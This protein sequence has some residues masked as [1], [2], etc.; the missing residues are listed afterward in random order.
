VAGALRDAGEPTPVGFLDDG[1]ATRQV[2]G[3]PVLGGTEEVV[4]V[5][6]RAGVTEVVVAIPSLPAT[7][8]ALLIDRA[9]AAGLGVR[10]LPAGTNDVTGL[11][12][13][14]L[15]RLLGRPEITV[16]G[17][18]ARRSITGRRV[19]VTGA[20]GVIGAH[21]CRLLE[22]LEPAELYRLDLDESRL[23]SLEHVDDRGRSVIADVRDQRR[24]SH[25]ITQLRPEVVF[26]SAGHTGDPAELE[27]HPSAAIETDVRGTRN[28]VSAAVRGG[29]ER[30]VL[31]STDQAADPSSVLGATR[32][33][34]E[35]TVQSAAGGP[36]IF[37]TVRIGNVLG[38]GASLLSVLTTQVAAGR[39]VPVTHPDVSRYF[40]TSQEA[41]GLILEAAAMSEEAETFVLDT[42]APT[43]VVELVHRYAAQLRLP[44]VTIRF[45]GLRP[46]ER[47]STKL[48][49]DGEVR[50]RTCHPMIWATRS[51]PLPSGVGDLLDEL[52]GAATSGADDRVRLLMRRILPEYRPR[53]SAR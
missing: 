30:F 12:R 6:E 46:G 52:V 47:L 50:V 40:M 16:A 15:G 5:A 35:L 38:A 25:L 29:V 8:I 13:V 37:G 21:L 7:R 24:I 2:G 31:V 36:T 26:H 34:S 9:C 42:G 48:F 49:S 23:R 44:E 33:L 20:C 53:E 18:R 4:H 32:R 10:Y 3:L 27:R 45:T 1:A 22:T 14:E 39:A 11:R 28:L 51:T 17:L 19:L 41:A 43:P